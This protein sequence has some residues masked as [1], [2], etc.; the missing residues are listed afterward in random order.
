VIFPI[1]LARVSQLCDSH[2]SEVLKIGDIVQV[3][4]ISVD[5]SKGKITLKEIK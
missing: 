4:V 3:K 2:P 1:R 5:V